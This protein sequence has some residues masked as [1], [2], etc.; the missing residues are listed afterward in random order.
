MGLQFGVRFRPRFGVPSGVLFVSFLESF[1]TFLGASGP[2]LGDFWRTFAALGVA[3]ETFVGFWAC[4]VALGRI[5]KVLGTFLKR[6]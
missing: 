1:W 4:L 5:C 6:C 3:F 2:P